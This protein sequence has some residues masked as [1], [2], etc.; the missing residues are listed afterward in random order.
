M[1]K[2]SLNDL[3]AFREVANQRSFSK[4]ADHLGVSRSALSHVIKGLEAYLGSQLL[5]RTTRSVSLTPAGQ[6]LFSGLSPILRDLD[7]L[8]FD[9]GNGKEHLFGEVRI[10]GSESAIAF[11]LEQVI[12]RFREHYPGIKLDLVSDGELSD[13]IE[14]GFDAGIRLGESLLKDMIAIPLGHKVRFIVVASPQYLQQYPAPITPSELNHHQCI[15]QR[16]PS[17][18]RYHWEFFKNGQS[19]TLDVPGNISLDNNTLMVSA[20]AQGMGIA[21]VPENYAK[22]QIASGNLVKILED[23]CPVEPGFHIYFPLYRHMSKSLRAF[24]NVIKEY[25]Q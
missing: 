22:A 2:P 1:K 19:V 16:L 9:A 17:G 11:L 24:I 18:K 21:F 14:G 5:R 8:L 6:H 13:I 7:Q 15:R 20:A 23:W 12:P 3:E 4:A 10:N 25:N